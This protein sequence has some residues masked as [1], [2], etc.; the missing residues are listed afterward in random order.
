[1]LY[2]INSLFLAVL[3]T[4]LSTQALAVDDCVTNDY[5]V[6]DEGGTITRNKNV[7]LAE[8]ATDNP[9]AWT[10]TAISNK[11]I[12]RAIK[13]LPCIIKRSMKKTEV[14]GVAV[15]VVRA[16]EVLFTG[17]FGLRKVGSPELVN[18]DTVFQLASLSKPIGATII[19]RAVSKGVVAWN[20][21]VID[22][23]P[24]FRIGGDYVSRNIT[25]GDLYSH[26]SGLPEHAGDE[27]E[28]LGFM[29]KQVL[30]RLAQLPLGLFREQYAYTNFG[31]TAAAEAVAKANNTNWEQ[32]S[33]DL[34]YR[35]AGMS[36]TS[37]RYSAYLSAENRAVNHRRFHGRWVVGP[38]RNAQ[39]QSPAGG[40]SSTANDM[41]K[42]M[43]L[44]LGNGVLD[45]LQLIR[46]E[47]LQIMRQ[48]HITSSHA[49]EPVARPAAYGFGIGTGVDGTGHVRWSHSG[50][51][52]SGVSAHVVFIPG[53]D[54]AITVLSNSE[55][56]GVPEAIAAAFV[57]IV[58]TGKERRDWLSAYATIFES[59]YV[60]QSI[61]ANQQR[62]AIPKP[63]RAIADYTGNYY[64]DYFGLVTVA[65]NRGDLMMSLG[66][67]PYYFSLTHWE[68]NMFAYFPRGENAV[69]VSAVIFDPETHRLTVENLNAQGLGEFVSTISTNAL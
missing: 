42:W 10:A 21:R 13:A 50:A 26:R 40:V 53:G 37:S 60:N 18:A 3:L 47:I 7:L 24:W 55:P 11:N 65:E 66:P 52:L 64:N 4:L 33:E 45:N 69:G 28:D 67:V 57:D 2:I 32:L 6:D 1:M 25:L 19:S 36:T 56:H 46:P 68:G 38:P 48:P 5:L 58:E 59:M 14:P 27:L 30:H 61:L 34:L 62:P 23:L 9:A 41:A 15:A 12:S 8:L 29:R 35:P 44:Q 49:K 39:A 16:N 54:L 43:Q 20:D 17:G 63:H 51:F 31:L 22:Y